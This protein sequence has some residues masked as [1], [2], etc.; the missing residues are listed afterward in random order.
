[1]VML[2]PCFN[3]TEFG[4]SKSTALTSLKNKTFNDES[5]SLTT[6]ELSTD[7]GESD[8]HSDVDSES[9]LFTDKMISGNSAPLKANDLW[10]LVF[11][12]LLNVLF[13]YVLFSVRPE[14]VLLTPLWCQ[15]TVHAECW[16]ANLFMSRRFY[17]WWTVVCGWVFLHLFYKCVLEGWCYISWRKFT[18][19]H[20]MTFGTEIFL[21]HFL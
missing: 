11:N 17:W 15:C 6:P 3:C 5:T 10:L 4:D 18:E 16:P 8:L 13:P 19:L 20:C 1:M 2:T 9:T 14:W 21:S 12:I 7:E